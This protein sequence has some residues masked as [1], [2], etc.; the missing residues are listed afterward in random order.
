ML[1]FLARLLDKTHRNCTI[2]IAHSWRNTVDLYTSIWPQT[3]RLNTRCE[4]SSLARKSGTWRKCGTCSCSLFPLPLISFS[5][6]IKFVSVRLLYFDFWTILVH[7]SFKQF[8]TWQTN[9][10][11]QL[12]FITFDTWTSTLHLTEMLILHSIRT[13]RISPVTASNFKLSIVYF[14]LNFWIFVYTSMI[15]G[16]D[17]KSLCAG[18]RWRP[19]DL[20]PWLFHPSCFLKKRLSRQHKTST[21]SQN[22]WKYCLLCWNTKLFIAVKEGFKVPKCPLDLN[23]SKI[24][25]CPWMGWFPAMF[26]HTAAQ[27]EA[28][29]TM[30]NCIDLASQ[31][32]SLSN[33]KLQLVF[34]RLCRL[35][36]RQND[37]AFVTNFKGEIFFRE[38]WP[39]YGNICIVLYF[40]AWS[41]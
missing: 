32:C 11:T 8:S 13:R 20:L 40:I 24:F 18:R 34:L 5:S 7:G 17:K 36:C 39:I 10:Y 15:I 29:S 1:R 25:V 12:L 31:D 22:V 6:A 3:T 41:V 4:Y 28:T 30:E 16:W 2:I 27:N 33:D 14:Q 26:D 9:F 37:R 21:S 19:I 23:N 35:L 38:N